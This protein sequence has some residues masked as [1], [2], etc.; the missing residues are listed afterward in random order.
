MNNLA[1]GPFLSVVYI[2]LSSFLASDAADNSDECFAENLLSL[3]GICRIVPLIFRVHNFHRIALNI[4]RS[5]LFEA[6]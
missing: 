1:C 6:V 3:C 5:L 2:N 4:D